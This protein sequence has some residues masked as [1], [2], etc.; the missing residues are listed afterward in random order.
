MLFEKLSLI[1]TKQKLFIFFLSHMINT[2]VLKKRKK[3]KYKKDFSL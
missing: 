1:K 2:I 3:H